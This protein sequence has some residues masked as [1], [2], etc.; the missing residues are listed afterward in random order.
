[1]VFTQALPAPGPGV[2]GDVMFFNPAG[3]AGATVQFLSTEMSFEGAVV[4]GAPYSAE[5]VTET[6]Q[7]LGDG[8][9]ITRKTS[10]S[11]YRDGEGRS[12]RDQAL[13]AVGPWATSGTPLVNVFINDP[14]LGVSYILDSNA[15]TARKQVAGKIGK[16]G[17]P[18]A[19][20]TTYHKTETV[21][22]SAPQSN[23]Q[24]LPSQLIEGVQAEG[25]RTTITIPAGEI[26]NDRPIEIVSE[27]WYSPEL[28]TVMMSKHSDPRMGETVYKLKGLLRGEPSRSLFDVPADYTLADESNPEV[29]RQHKVMV[30]KMIIEHKQ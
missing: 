7:T 13:P 12:R 30:E 10:A 24:A 28:K 21:H 9:R 29:L 17:A 5:A 25:T 8:N 16:V 14:V 19:G 4:K 27:R 6:T 2:G 11:L 23:E 22:R 3:A 18:A 26:G 15:K 1:M 20:I